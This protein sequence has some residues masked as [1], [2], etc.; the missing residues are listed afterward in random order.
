MSNRF[1]D[2][3]DKGKMRAYFVGATQSIAGYEDLTGSNTPIE[4][5]KELIEE[6]EQRKEE[7]TE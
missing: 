6:Y 3:D 1:S 4:D 5:L 7:I 2:M